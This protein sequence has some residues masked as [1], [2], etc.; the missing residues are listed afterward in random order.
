[1]RIYIY[2][3]N[4]YNG[5]LSQGSRFVFNGNISP[6]Y[7][8]YLFRPFSHIAAQMFT[9]YMKLVP[10]VYSYI[11]PKVSFPRFVGNS[12]TSPQSH[13]GMYAC[14]TDKNRCKFLKF[15]TACFHLSFICECTR[16]C[17]G[18]FH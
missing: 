7:H 8:Y 12:V 4:I 6:V 14:Q 3:C 10:T 17:M 15:F 16:S 2:V 9:Y 5:L 1:M 13:T 11:D 18:L